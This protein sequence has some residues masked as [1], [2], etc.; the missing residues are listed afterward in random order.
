MK[1]FNL[2]LT[3]I[4][5]MTSLL[6]AQETFEGIGKKGHYNKTV[7]GAEAFAIPQL[8][9]GFETFVETKQVVQESKLSNLQNNFSAAS[10]GKQYGGRQ[11][12]SART[13][14]I[15]NADME[16]ADFQELA[17]DFQ[18]ILEGEIRNAGFKVYGLDELAEKPSYGKIADK[19]SN[20]T[21]KKA[22]KSKDEDIGQGQVK[23]LPENGLFMF[24]DKSFATGGVAFTVAMKNF[25]Q[26]TNAITLLQNISIDFSTVEMNV[27]ID[28]GRKGKTTTADTKVLPKMHINDNSFYF[29]GKN[30]SA[31][32][33]GKLNGEYI[34][35]KEYSAKIYRDKEK[36]KSLF[37]K[38]FA[39]GT[40]SIDFDPF[41]VEM[42]KE[43]YKDAARELFTQYSKD[44]ASSLAIAANGK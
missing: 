42:S 10:K 44:F 13:T 18:K 34:S 25:Y 7:K 28:A 5:C 40:P 17:N 12:S 21:E 20:K 1:K 27:A 41:I 35:E 14:T 36:G 9:I 26:E 43:T 30:G 19:F 15:L 2:T 38:M 32:Y 6:M 3:L 11:S 39:I 23:V 37:T 24:D 31:D 8:A 33:P 22:K 4:F 16:L 29:V